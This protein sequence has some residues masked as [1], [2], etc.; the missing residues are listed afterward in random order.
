MALCGED[1]R[2]VVIPVRAQECECGETVK[3]GT[4]QVPEK[5]VIRFHNNNTNSIRAKCTRKIRS[6]E[7]NTSSLTLIN[8]TFSK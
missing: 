5:L 1:W 4:V 2:W 3:T 7:N 6:N 8:S